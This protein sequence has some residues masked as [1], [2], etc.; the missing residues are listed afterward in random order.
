MWFLPFLAVVADV[1]AF[2]FP[3]YTMTVS[4]IFW[5]SLI[6]L[7]FARRRTKDLPKC[8]GSGV[9]MQK[10]AFWLR[11]PGAA[12]YISVGLVAWMVNWLILG[13]IAGAKDSWLW[14]LVPCVAIPPAIPAIFRTSPS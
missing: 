10:Y 1:A 14:M 3:G 11:H 4:L 8:P 12:I 2:W 5:F 7:I 6:A 9:V 13:I